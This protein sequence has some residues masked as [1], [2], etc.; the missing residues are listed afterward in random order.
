MEKESPETWKGKMQTG[1]WIISLIDIWLPN[2][3]LGIILRKHPNHWSFKRIWQL[4]EEQRYTIN[5]FI[6]DSEE[7]HTKTIVK[8]KRQ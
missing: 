8:N 6:C 4:S 5:Y 1:K 7:K 2:R 3:I